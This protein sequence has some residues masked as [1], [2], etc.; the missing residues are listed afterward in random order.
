MGYDGWVDKF[1]QT[2]ET[3]MQNCAQYQED[4]DGDW[5]PNKSYL[6]REKYFDAQRILHDRSHDDIP[7]VRQGNSKAGNGILVAGR[8]EDASV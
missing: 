1:D 2:M 5:H 4:M 7:T 8:N 6:Q 3:H